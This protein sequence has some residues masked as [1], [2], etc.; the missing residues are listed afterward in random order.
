MTISVV[1]PAYNE[2]KLLPTCLQALLNQ[3]R[4]PDE[5]IVVDNNSSDQTASVARAYGVTIVSETQQGIMPA[6][7]TGMVASK[8]D[9]IARCDA[10][11]IVPP[12]WLER[13]EMI[14]QSSP[15]AAGVTGVGKFYGTGRLRANFAQSWYMYAYFL[16]VGSA[17]ANWPIFGS[18]CAIRRVVWREIEGSVHRERSDVHDDMDISVHI[19]PTQPIIFRPSLVVGISARAL[20]L[21]DM[22]RRYMCGWKTLSLHWPVH[23]PWRRW[24]AKLRLDNSS[25]L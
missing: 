19:P 2:E 25:S 18:N 12:D 3:A 7:Y 10:D 22:K 24:R 15:G 1:V 9:I 23:S 8:G 13:I 17:L 21:S 6:V 5:I 14:L 11:S 20:R 4:P 16:L